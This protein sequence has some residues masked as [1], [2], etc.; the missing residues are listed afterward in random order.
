[1]ANDTL[2]PA[3]RALRLLET[4]AQA[5]QGLAFSDLMAALGSPR[6]TLARQLK[7][8]TAHRYLAKDSAT[9]RYRSGPATAALLGGSERDRLR[10]LAMPVLADLSA[11]TAQSAAV[12]YRAGESIECLCKQMHPDSLTMQE[13]GQR[14]MD[15]STSPWGWW[16]WTTLSANEQAALRACQQMPQNLAAIDI[17][18]RAWL[19]DDCGQLAHTRRLAA[20]VY[21]DSGRMLACIGMAG[22]A[23]VLT[24]QTLT[25]VGSALA[26][27]ART[28]SLR[29]GWNP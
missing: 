18:D 27:A 7:D 6:A 20:P 9:G 5:P 16:F 29:L 4:V 12:F 21:D 2:S 13:I 17:E 14:S 25:T 15:C 10:R 19:L 1:M 26:R 3:V 22:M 24:D 28:L 11:E 23:A 8:L